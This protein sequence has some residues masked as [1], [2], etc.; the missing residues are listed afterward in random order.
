M[1]TALTEK[2]VAPKTTEAGRGRLVPLFDTELRYRPD[3]GPVVSAEDHEG[4]LIGSGEGTVR[5]E[6]IRGTIRWTF[7]SV[8]C[9]LPK[10]LTGAPLPPGLHLCRENPGG[11][12]DTEDGARIWFDARGFGLRGPDP[13]RPHVWRL[14]MGI[15]FA[16]DDPR[17]AWLST[18][19]GLWEGEFN[20]KVGLSW[21][22]A[23]ASE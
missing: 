7:Y 12:I 9:V 16:T 18:T 6:R 8:N 4:E 19:L 17:Y 11:Y 23:Y 14:T 5:G 13:R 21:Y 2:A 1:S 10:V 22:R 20:E 3:M 15:Q